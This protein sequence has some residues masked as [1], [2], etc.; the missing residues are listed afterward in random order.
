MP[1]LS[2]LSNDVDV[3]RNIRTCIRLRLSG[4]SIDPRT[5]RAPHWREHVSK[6]LRLAEVGGFHSDNQDDMDMCHRIAHAQ[7]RVLYEPLPTVHHFVPTTRTTWHYFWRK[8]YFANQQKSS[9]I[10]RY[11]G[12]LKSGCGTDLCQRYA[13]E[14]RPGWD[15]PCNPR[16]P[17]RIRTHRRDD[18]GIAL[19][20][21]GHVSRQV[22]L[23]RSRR[24]LAIR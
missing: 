2:G 20:G 9:G 10:R 17:V 11:G 5:T 4:S 23:R 13:D 18:C 22:R 14:G 6:T 12:S 8:C 1:C 7:H 19:A 16:W 15:S 21:L 24:V 3:W